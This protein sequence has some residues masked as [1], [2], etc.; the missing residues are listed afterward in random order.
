MAKKKS[1]PAAAEQKKPANARREPFAIQLRVPLKASEIAASADKAAMLEDEIEQKIEAQK[2]Q[3]KI[4][5]SGIAQ[6]SAEK[7]RLQ[8]EVRT[9]AAYREVQCERRFLYD[10]GV[11]TEVRLDTGDEI[12]TRPMTEAEK[13]Q[14]LPFSPD[15]PSPNTGASGN[16][17]D[18][19]FGNA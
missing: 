5:R 2:A 12:A 11:V 19:E 8:S 1:E 4:V 10:E 14:F 18:D 7:R 3:A 16:D 6:D 9:K 13:Q 15:D 17:L